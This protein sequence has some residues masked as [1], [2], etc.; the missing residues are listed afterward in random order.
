MIKLSKAIEVL[1]LNVK[2]AHKNMPQDVKDAL[3]L[4]INCM[5]TVQYI[6][7]GGDWSFQALFPDEAPVEHEN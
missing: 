1:D 7:S 6:R 3:N 4:A 5:K 2:E